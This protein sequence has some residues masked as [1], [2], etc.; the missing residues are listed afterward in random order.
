MCKAF[1]CLAVILYPFLSYAQQSR[2]DFERGLSVME[3]QGQ[4]RREGN[5][6]I[7]LNQRPGDTAFA[8]QLYNKMLEKVDQSKNPYT[9]A[10]EIGPRYKNIK[11]APNNNKPAPQTTPAVIAKPDTPK[12]M[13]YKPQL[14][15]ANTTVRQFMYLKNGDFEQGYFRSLPGWRID[16]RAFNQRQGNDIYTWNHFNVVSMT[17]IGGDYWEDI[18]FH[19]GYKHQHWMTSR[20][21]NILG[22]AND[23][24]GATGTLTSDPFKLYP[25]QNFIS[26]LVSGGM[27]MNNLKVEFLQLNI[28]P[29]LTGNVRSLTQGQPPALPGVHQGAVGAVMDTTYQSVRGISP[30]TGHNSHIF[31]REYWDVHGLDTSKFYVIRVTDNSTNMDWGII[32]VDDFRMLKYNPTA[33]SEGDDSLKVQL[34]T[35]KD[36][37]SNLDRQIVVDQ[38]VPI[39]GAVDLH[40]HLMS[41]LGFGRKLLYGA[42]DIGSIVPAGT[43]GCNASDY[44]AT[45]VE[46]CLGNCNSAHGGWGIDNTCGN[47][48]RAAV[49][50]FAFDGDYE[51]RVSLDRNPH[52]DHPHEGYPNFLYWPH[53]SSVSHQQMY[54]DWIR[55]AYQGGLRVL[56]TL[57]VNSELLGGVVSGDPPFDDKSA[58]DL[59]LNE[60]VSFV[61]RHSDFM[62]IAYKPE[63]LRSIVRSNK[64]AVVI[65]MEVDNIGNF[66]YSNVNASEGA[67]AAE[68]QR[69]Y[70]K[71]VRYIFPIHLVNN[72]FG[73]S[74]IYS[75][76]FNLSNKYTTSR[77]LPWG[78]P[79]PPGHMFNVEPA[80]DPRIKYT[81]SLTA[82]TPTDGAMNAA[83]FGMGGFLTG[84]AELPFPPALNIDPGSPDF[85]PVPKLGCIQQFKIVQSLLTMSSDWDVYNNIPGGQQ[86]QL[87]LTDLGKFAIRQMMKLGMI[88]DIDHMSDHS[89]RDALA[90]A[91]QFNYPVASG[92]NGL[93]DGIF[94][95]PGHKVSENQRTNEQ[96]QNI[97]RLGG[98]FGLGIGESTAGQYL[99]NFRL[100]MSSTKMNGAA[101]MIGSDINGCVVMP[102]PRHGDGR[103]GE[104]SRYGGGIYT[105]WAKQIN[106]AAPGQPTYSTTGGYLMR[107]YAFGNKSW[108]YNTEGV[109]HIGLFP[110]YFQDLKN[111]GMTRDERQ[112]F[113]TAA[114]YFVSMWDRC[115]KNKGNVR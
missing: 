97:R 56:V 79:I 81:L 98:V 17:D 10:F 31:R 16:G 77:P 115:E 88:V 114:D 45:S 6:I 4:I 22:N 43:Y 73:G 105:N 91:N 60:I 34:I 28:G 58:A 89:V 7:V 66:N 18:K 103:G 23:G 83:I 50:N 15:Q 36:M 33:N 67:V 109:A 54:V 100:A 2:A 8:R 86:N 12:T 30:K 11:P 39:Y 104:R 113:F 29:R 26:F 102:K 107:K 68:I 101:I 42:P 55:R 110:D 92:H 94:E 99:A 35:I 112:V 24:G 41:Y 69:L 71:G 95:D 93:R 84:L 61:G 64:M 90:L 80:S 85:C 38:Y 70:Q 59:Q 49:L 57:T 25:N 13:V 53:F 19:I 74:A 32:N 63:D 62:Q 5:K 21:D 1:L 40:T 75:L 82:G 3:K 106:Y 51:K 47:Y 96:L 72:K 20:T 46:Q 78:T 9:I 14:M 44:R 87:G 108:D 27:D 52:G 111:L 48:I 76:L 37:V 65:G